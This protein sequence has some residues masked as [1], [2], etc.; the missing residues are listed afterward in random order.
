MKDQILLTSIHCLDRLEL[1]RK[2]KPYEMRF[3]PPCDFPRKNI[4]ISKYHGIPVEDIRARKESLSIN[5]NGF[6]V[7]ELDGQMSP[8][9]FSDREAIASQYLPKVAEELKKCL[10]ASRVQIHDYLVSPC[11]R[12]ERILAE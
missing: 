10:G 11:Q 3:Y 7:M 2:E 5:K 12:I 6:M 9:D 4:H 1:Y 8:E